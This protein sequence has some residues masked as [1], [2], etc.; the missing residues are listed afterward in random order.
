MQPGRQDHQLGQPGTQ[1]EGAA[2]AVLQEDAVQARLRLV[3]RR[4]EPDTEGFET[5]K[6]V[7]PV[8][9][10][11][12]LREVQDA[13]RQQVCRSKPAHMNRRRLSAVVRMC[14]RAVLDRRR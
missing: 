13:P 4:E 5:R 7:R 12:H 2:H 8:R 9:V 14:P 11:E 10:Y 6:L 3:L 1:E